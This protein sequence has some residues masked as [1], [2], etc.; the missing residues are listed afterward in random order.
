MN[1]DEFLL[2]YGT[3]IKDAVK[4]IQNGRKIIKKFYDKTAS[5]VKIEE[6]WGKVSDRVSWA[7]KKVIRWAESAFEGDYP[8]DI[9]DIVDAAIENQELNGTEPQFALEAIENMES[10]IQRHMK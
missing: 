1:R 8:I 10:A 4:S 7:D 9:R 3:E 6:A 5:E 2:N